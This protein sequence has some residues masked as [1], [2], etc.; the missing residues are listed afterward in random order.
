MAFFI[1]GLGCFVKTDT[2]KCAP[3]YSSLMFSPFILIYCIERMYRLTR[4]K[5]LINKV[6]FYHN[7]VFKIEFEKIFTYKSGQYVMLCCP[8]ISNNQW[9]SFTISSFPEEYKI[10]LT[11]KKLGNWTQKLAGILK[12]KGSTSIKVDGPFNSPCDSIYDFDSSVVIATGIGITPFISIIKDFVYKYKCNTL[13]LKKID[14]IWV[15]RETENFDW[16]NG[17]LKILSDAIPESRLKFHVYLTQIIDTST[18]HRMVSEPIPGLTY[19]KGTEILLHYGR[20]DFDKFFKNY[21]Y[22]NTKLRV[23]CF[24][25]GPDSLQKTVKKSC[26]SHSNKNITFTCISEKF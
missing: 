21:S 6:K 3:Y 24:V 1:H 19:I 8:E 15:S 18:I 4:R 20:P 14:I 17:V 16:F 5:I 22:N 25:C 2:G 26:I 23:G 9:H 13:D 11:I 7:N 12:E 10:E